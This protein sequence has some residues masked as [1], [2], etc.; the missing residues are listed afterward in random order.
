VLGGEC[1]CADGQTGMFCEHSVAVGLCYLAENEPEW[2]D[3]FGYFGEI[4][5][6]WDAVTADDLHKMLVLHPTLRSVAEASEPE[7]LFRRCH[8][9]QPRRCV[10]RSDVDAATTPGVRTRRT[11]GR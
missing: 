1:A 7:E 9:T 5:S 4:A 11:S 10:S 6:L 3:G 8:A 2:S